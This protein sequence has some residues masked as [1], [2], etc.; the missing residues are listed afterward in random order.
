MNTLQ[1]RCST[2]MSIS[3]SGKDE[4]FEVART[5][6][7]GECGSDEKFLRLAFHPSLSPV[8]CCPLNRL[9]QIIN[10]NIQPVGSDLVWHNM[11]T[12]SPKIIFLY[13]GLYW[14]TMYIEYLFGRL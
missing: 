6:K 5:R 10:C 13:K 9:S 8:Q 4:N 7:L 14:F 1:K 3:I 2:I 11:I 12:T